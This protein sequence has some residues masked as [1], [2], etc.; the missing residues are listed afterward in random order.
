M[1]WDRLAAVK[2]GV[3][4]VKAVSAP[5]LIRTVGLGSCVGVVVYDP[6]LKVAAMAHVML[7]DS[8]LAGKRPYPPGKFADSAVKEMV[9]MLEK[10]GSDGRGLK[11]KAAGGAEMF[12]LAAYG[13]VS[14]IGPRNV[15]AV[16]DQLAR[17]GI[18]MTAADV[19]KNYGRTI[20]F[21]PESEKLLIRTVNRGIF[22]I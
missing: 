19:G 10:L 18:E 1:E 13:G 22:E 7:P 11:A 17:F 21:N 16:E 2:V 5:R 8:S 12:D 3:S 15:A 20:E 4:E 14:K 6:L 9:A